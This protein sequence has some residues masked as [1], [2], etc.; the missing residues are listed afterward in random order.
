MVKISDH[1][2][3]S[4]GTEAALFSLLLKPIEAV[5]QGGFVPSVPWLHIY[6]F[7]QARH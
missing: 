6:S 5:S 4:L 1:Q 3:S 2:H 7:T